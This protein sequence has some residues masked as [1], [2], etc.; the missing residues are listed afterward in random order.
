[1]NMMKKSMQTHYLKAEEATLHGHFSSNLEPVLSINPGDIVSYQLLD[2]GWGLENYHLDGKKR[3]CLKPENEFL[4]QGHCLAGPI[5]IKGAVEGM[6][7]VVHIKDIIPEN[8]GWTH[9][10]GWRTHFNDRLGVSLGNS[11]LILWEID[12]DKMSARCDNYELKI[13]PFLGVLGMPPNKIGVHPTFPPRFCGGNLDCK[14]LTISV[15]IRV[16]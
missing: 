12:Y 5:E 2:A 6:T 7:L 11:K 9:A 16:L 1:M 3:K 14:E 13:N 8:W 15:K 4:N 10:G